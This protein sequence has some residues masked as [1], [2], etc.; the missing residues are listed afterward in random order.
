MRI[1]VIHNPSSGAGNLT[2]RQLLTA[3]KSDGHEVSYDD[4]HRTNLSKKLKAPADVVIAAGGDGTVSAVARRLVGSDKPL[5]AVPLGTANN[6]AKGLAMELDLDKVLQTLRDPRDKRMDIGVASGA[7]G[8]RTFVESAGIGLFG[9]ALD[10]HLSKEDKEPAR[11]AGVLAQLL[12]KYRAHAWEVTIDGQEA[13]DRYVLIDAMNVPMMGPNLCLSPGATPFDGLLDIV[14]VTED[15]RETLADYLHALAN[16]KKKITAPALTVRRAKHIGVRLGD[17]GLRLDDKV[18]P[19]VGGKSS[20]FAD[21]RVV[22]GALR[23]WLPPVAE[24]EG[25]RAASPGA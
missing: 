16:Q 4:D 11:A 8:E 3:L 20:Y 15:Q 18:R 9:H 23:V 19:R 2:K 25:T 7:W 10:E 24:L 13:N 14:L 17:H 21:I 12:E 5:I 6:L 22:P 1:T